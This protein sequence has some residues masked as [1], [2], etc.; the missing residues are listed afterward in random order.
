LASYQ[1]IYDN[2][3]LCEAAS[4]ALFAAAQILTDQ[5]RRQQACEHL[6]QLVRQHTEF[7]HRDGALYQLA[8]LQL[9]AGKLTQADLR[10][11]QLV[12]EHQRSP[13]WADATF[14]LARNAANRH[15]AA[16]ANYWLD[17]LLFGVV[18]N[19]THDGPGPPDSP[20][21]SATT[22]TDVDLIVCHALYL[23]GKLAVDAGQWLAALRSYLR[24]VEEHPQSD[25][26]SAAAFWAAD[27]NFH[28]GHYE[29]ADTML[30]QQQFTAA[31]PQQEYRAMIPL[32]RAQIAV[33][34]QQ[35]ADALKLAEGIRI[36]FPKF[37]L[38]FEADYVIG[39]CLNSQARFALARQSF[40]QVINAPLAQ[41]TET[42]AMAQWM[43]GETYFH[44][45]NYIDAIRAYYRVE[46]LYDLPRWQAA[47]LLQAAKC[48]ELNDQWK[49]AH[50]LYTQLRSDYPESRFAKEATRRLRVSARGGA[51]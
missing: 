34:R 44:Q 42:A 3:P 7:E 6:E 40:R 16:Q 15:D 36:R 51:E 33:H 49:E 24:V 9:E 35:W 21:D 50:Q 28:L 37:N 10:F 27:A 4:S 8:W 25:L 41:R 12:K 13:L 38:Q 32:R 1:K 18:R 11:A 14:R 26:A 48:H 39:R 2:D 47:A 19:A 23:Q 45:S 43:I 20:G 17:E 30:A 31:D 46:A 22:T 5:G 29:Q